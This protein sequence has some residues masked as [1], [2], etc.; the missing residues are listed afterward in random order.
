MMKI[1]NKCKSIIGIILV[2]SLLFGAGYYLG[3]HRNSEQH[4]A[5]VDG[6]DMQLPG[7]TERMVLTINEVESKLQEIGELSSCEGIYTV[8]RG[9]DFT[10]YLIDKIPVPGTTNHVEIE[11]NGV[12]K[13]GYKI[14]DVVPTIDEVSK[15]IYIALPEITMTSNEILWDNDMQSYDINTPLNPID[16]DEYK[17]VI[18]EIKEEGLQDAIKKGLY[19]TAESNAHTVIR[20]FLGCFVDYE[21]KFI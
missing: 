12:V 13:V 2:A 14:D 5:T 19:E 10:R 4:I 8:R 17:T 3:G 16:F 6:F 20:N 1:F 7:E 15:T 18:A 9:K 11:C 21:V